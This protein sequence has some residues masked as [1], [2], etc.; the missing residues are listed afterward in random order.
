MTNTM[1]VIFA[2]DP[3][4]ADAIECLLRYVR[5]DVSRVR[6]P[7]RPIVLMKGPLPRDAQDNAKR[8]AIA[9]T[10]EARASGRSVTLVIAHQDCDDFEPAHVPLAARIVAA[11]T[12]CEV[13][14]PIAAVPAWE[15][16]AWWYLWPDAVAAVCSGW[17]K[18]TRTGAI[19]MI[20]NA[21]EQLRRDLRP[22]GRTKV[23]DYDPTY[24]PRIGKKVLEQ[25]KAPT[26]LVQSASFNAFRDALIGTA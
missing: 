2:E 15:L 17:R 23:P 10:L 26:A 3:T 24:G 8:L 18:L 25:G 22:T 20:R 16:E 4:D 12:V 11:L 1:A 21:K 14:H 9:V 7:R 13:P 6:K 19:G 5:P